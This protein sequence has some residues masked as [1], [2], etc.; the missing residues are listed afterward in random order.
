MASYNPYQQSPYPQGPPSQ[1][2]YGPD[3]PQ[4]QYSGTP[5]AGYGLQGTPQQDQGYFPPQGQAGVSNDGGMGGLTGQM[6]GMG[7]GGDAAAPYRPN[8]KKNRHAYHNLE[9]PSAPPQA[10]GAQ[11]P[12]QFGHTNADTSQQYGTAHPYAGQQVTPAMNQFPAPASAPFSPGLQAPNQAFGQPSQPNPAVA[13]PGVSQGKVDPEQIPSIPRFRD[14]AA[15]YYLDHVYPTMEQHLPPPASVPFVAHDQGNSSP[16]FA[17]LTLNNIPSTQEA[18]T[19]TSLP[20]GIVLQPLAPLQD[21]EQAVPVLDFG[22]VGPPRCRRCRTY[23]NPFMTFRSGGNKL[24]C[25]MCTFPNDVPPEYFAPTDPSGVRVDRAQRPE[26]TMGTVEFM[27]PKEYWAK[28]PVGL[29]WLFLIDVGQEAINRGFLQA[30]CEGVLLALYGDHQQDEE[31]GEEPNGEAPEIPRR[32][33]LVSKVAFV[34][35]DRAMYFFNCNAKLDQ[36]QMLVMPDL[37]EPFVP[38]GSDG[39]FVDPYE[40]KSVITGLLQRLPSLFSGNKAPEPALLPALR[41]T[42]AALALTGGKIVCSLSAL[43][44]WGP[45]RL[46][47]RDKNDLHGIDT[48]RKL[49]QTEHAEWRTMASKLVASG[50]GVDFF[51]AAASGGYMDIATIGHIS[52]VSGGETYFYPTFSAPRDVQRLTKEIERTVTRETGYQALMKVRCSNG[53]Q[54][55]SYHGNFLQHNFGADLELGSIDAD[56]ALGVMFSYDGKLDS[57]LDAHFQCA[58]LYTTASG[59]RRVR[60]TNTVASVSES[61]PEVMRFLDQDAIVTMIAKEAATRMTERTLKDIRN[62]LTEKTIDILAGHRRTGSVSHPPGQLVLPENLKEFGMYILGLLKSRAFKAGHEPSDRR[63]HTMRFLKSASPL[64]ISLFLYPRIVPLHSLPDNSCFPDPETGHL[65]VPPCLRASFG[66]IED[67]GAYLVD[68]GQI[69]LLWLH[70]HVSPNLLEDLFGPGNTNL[71][72]LDHTLSSL[73]VLETHLNAQARNLIAYWSSVRGSKAL[74]LQLARQGL[75]GAEYEFAR[76]LVEDRNNEAQ[77]YVDWLVHLHRGIQ[78]ELSGQR[79][80]EEG[81]GV[82]A[83]LEGAMAGLSN[84][85][86]R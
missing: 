54:V 11:P 48:E 6:G 75:D 70:E 77:S 7:L 46:F 20:L 29:H 13:G 31:D 15:Q 44:T 35:F 64:E 25:N 72:D 49:F 8:K 18:L 79:R 56:K 5:Q 45:G 52:A 22:D 43:P 14:A 81:E 24:V 28:E 66:R 16:K 65:I 21:G 53:L 12:G 34:T 74:T 57:K 41:A 37:E 78:L 73:P 26:L 47:L 51:L 71:A 4:S 10:F 69:C 59:E 61:M 82:G 42:Q 83:G 76:L 55:S 40:S 32:I 2:Q 23:I 58:L 84:L 30:F 50:I 36:A 33:P 86:G 62:A 67:G 27:V 39:L 1:S 60:C 63:T 38:L 3:G 85:I 80:K 19:T 17:R 9:Q 68:D